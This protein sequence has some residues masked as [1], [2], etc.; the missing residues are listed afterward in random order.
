VLRRGSYATFH[1]KLGACHQA[2]K[3]I[4]AI[5]LPTR[6]KIDHA[7]EQNEISFQDGDNH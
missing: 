2:S 1:N 6:Y 7:Q 3:F 5:F 4:G